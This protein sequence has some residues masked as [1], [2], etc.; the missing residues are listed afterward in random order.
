MA[1]R[2]FTPEE[3]LACQLGIVRVRSSG[4]KQGISDEFSGLCSLVSDHF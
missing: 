1:R 2:H 3:V 4:Q